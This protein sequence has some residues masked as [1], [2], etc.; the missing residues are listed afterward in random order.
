MLLDD[1]L[2]SAK[3]T[4]VERLAS[5][6][7]GSFAVAW[8]AWNY[9]FLVILFSSTGVT[10]TFALIQAI[11]FP[12]AWSILTRGIAYPLFSAGAYVFLYPYP[13]RFIYEFTLRR[14]REINQTKQRISDETPLT[15]EESQKLRAEFV[16]RE[17]AHNDQVQRL[18]EEVA[19]L[20]AA[21]DLKTN[22]SPAPELSPAERMYDSLELGQL[23][24][25]QVVETSNGPMLESEL[26]KASKESRVKTEYDIGEL[27]R[28][29]LLHRDFDQSKRG[30]TVEFTHSGRKALLDSNG[31][32]A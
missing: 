21:L 10:Q 7:L 26:V 9:K 4:I 31:S 5:P 1:L 16:A 3:Q 12:D 29:K 17:R 20:N 27:V 19:R 15:L 13:A 14:Q 6:L 25:L 32:E 24:L 22:P 28:R 30:Y 18:N 8:C 11:S 23:R 2:T